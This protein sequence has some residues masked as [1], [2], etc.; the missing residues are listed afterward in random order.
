[1][2]SGPLVLHVRA[3]CPVQAWPMSVIHILTPSNMHDGESKIQAVMHNYDH[4]HATV[5]RY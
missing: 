1:M 5:I 3:L 2:K 4:V